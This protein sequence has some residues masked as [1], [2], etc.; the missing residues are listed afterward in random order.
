M[1]SSN[2]IDGLLLELALSIGT[3]SG[4]NLLDST[5]PLFI[6]KLNC[7]G[8][9]VLKHCDQSTQVAFERG[10]S[11][12]DLKLLLEQYLSL[13]DCN[14]D[15]EPYKIIKGESNDLYIFML[16]TFGLVIFQFEKTPESDLLKKILPIINQLAISCKVSHQLNGFCI[17]KESFT[18][19][20]RLLHEI[21]DNIPDP[22]YVKDRQGK[23]IFLNAAEAKLLGA[24][25]INEVIGKDDSEFYQ[26]DTAIRTAA[27]DRIIIETGKSV[28]HREEILKTVS[29]EE[30]WI[31]G[32]K[33]PHLDEKGNVAGI[34]GIS[35]DV[36][37]YK[38]LESELRVVANKYKSIFNS[39]VDLYYQTDLNGIIH[40]VSPSV[41]P[42]SGYKPE[43]L[44][45]KS[46]TMVYA[47]V[48]RREEMV[49]LLLEHGSVNDYENVLVHKIGKH[50]PVSITCHLI[51]DANGTPL[52]IEGTIRDITQ[53]KET[54]AK[55]NKVLH[56]QNLITHLA[57]E[58]INIPLE[59]S[60]GA[61]DRLLSTIGKNIDIDR[62]Y[63]YQY[64]FNRNIVTGTNEW[65]AGG[66]STEIANLQAL[67]MSMLQDWV[68]AHQRGETVRFDDISEVADNKP[69]FEMLESHGVKSLVT[70]PLVLNGECL[71]FVGFDAV[72]TFR[73]WTAEEITFLQ[74][75]ADL[76]CNVTD[77][78]RKDEALFNRE[79]SLKAIFN[80]VPFQMWLKDTDSRYIAINKPFMDYFSINHE[81]EIIGKNAIDIW[82][83]ETANHFMDE[84]KKVMQSLELCSVEELV[85]F[86]H[87]S[88]WFEIFRAPI[89]GQDGKILGTTGIAR[90][91]NNRKNAEKELQLA[92][93]TAEA[94]NEAK[95]KFL[96]IMSHEIRNPL[97]AVVGMVRMLYEAGIKGPNS[98]LVENIK[99]SSDHLLTIINDILDFSKIESGEMFLE[100]TCFNLHDA[101][102]QVYN[103][104]L[105]IAKDRQIDLEF[106]FDK[107]IAA[108]YLGDPHRLQQVLGNL[109]NNALKFTS[110][111][112]IDIRC[113]IEKDSADSSRIRFEVEDTGIGIS[114]E[115]QKRIFESFKQE[116]D[117]I[118]RTHGG[119]GLGLAISKQI[120]DLMGGQLSVD[121][122]K[123]VGSKFYFII[124]LK[125]DE[126]VVQQL[127]DKSESTE[128]QSLKGYKVLLVE[129]NML[130]Q[131][132]AT[133]MLEKWGAKVEV[134]GNGQIAL[135]KV[136]KSAFDI[137]L[138]DIQMPVMDGM[139]ASKIIREK[140][141]STVPILAL[142]ANVIKGIVEKCKEAGMQ[143]YISKPFEANDLFEK[144]VSHVAKTK[145]TV[146]PVTSEKEYEEETSGAAL[147]DISRL[148][149]MIGS[150]QIQL[151]RMLNK[152]LEI[153]PA[154][155]EELN[156]AN[157]SNDVAAVAS[158]SHKIK[159]S[160]DL[161]SAQEMRD[162]I[163]KIS[164]DSK[165]GKALAEIK[166]DIAMFNVYYSKLEKELKQEI[167]TLK[168]VLQ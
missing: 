87:K 78:K 131:I 154:Y 81:N 153:T 75:L 28:I 110:E 10:I 94:A 56:L 145:T 77:R 108:S 52:F 66:I 8:A 35:H 132:L 91:I 50:I 23:K 2:N 36:T 139:T 135:D 119:T 58:F 104:H 124:D 40:E 53:R 67:P 44:I 4:S 116:D 42:L 39:F 80:N 7:S 129:D 158:T 54:E 5:L 72:K 31:Q 120:V 112:K 92:V 125:K 59:K 148:K 84:D 163:C 93:Q 37:A 9:A 109:T 30:I 96:A 150:D 123:N 74:L 157:T 49:N 13:V 111:G 73:N 76:L 167:H 51:K 88:V 159:S 166:P 127:P 107:N 26:Y 43:E 33:I 142:S 100:E 141:N 118:S 21:I 82:D 64:D 90:D 165:E 105:F 3:N 60:S 86:K 99:I 18:N 15:N 46:V 63:V 65:C 29:G 121:S 6:D 151:N 71:G 83:N 134:A 128:E 38:Q 1:T 160:I 162:L 98:K 85:D 48:K 168:T 16:S 61:V 103:S 155:L 41:Y 126:S 106:H 144:I 143:G 19:E 152:F 69:L 89:I 32:T 114:E 146:L 34:I 47:D 79:A 140:L 138:M 113:K 24:K 17:E 22:I 25:D 115:G 14:P 97:S 70:I 136:E 137:I 12:N 122:K 164:Q 149:K 101:V 147:S 11:K 102:A 55:L 45:G 20:R 95:S 161:V 133:T 62:V 57:T 130:N 117:S 27:E 156:V 68:D